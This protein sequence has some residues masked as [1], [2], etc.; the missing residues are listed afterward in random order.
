MRLTQHLICVVITL[1]CVGCSNIKPIFTESITLSEKQKAAFKLY[2]TKSRV[3]I[4]LFDQAEVRF[5]GIIIGFDEFMNLVIEDCEE[6][7]LKKGSRNYLGRIL[8]KGD[9]LSLVRSLDT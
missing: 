9:N 4:W 2:Q 8:M 5:E 3:Q 1:L 6:I 7:S